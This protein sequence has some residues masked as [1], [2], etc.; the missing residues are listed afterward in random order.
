MIIYKE[1]LSP[2]HPTGVPDPVRLRFRGELNEVITQVLHEQQTA[3]AA[4]ATLG[5]SEDDVQ[6]F[7]PILAQELRI[8]DVYNCARYRLS[9]DLVQRWV[10][11]G[12][13]H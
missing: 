9:M 4:T 12:R 1:M 11:A 5:M 7:R 13:P 10:E 6:L 2:H 3:E 8:L